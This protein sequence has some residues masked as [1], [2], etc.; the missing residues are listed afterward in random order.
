MYQLR[1]FFRKFIVCPEAWDRALCRWNMFRTSSAAACI[2]LHQGDHESAF[3]SQSKPSPVLVRL[4]SSNFANPLNTCYY[5]SYF[6][7]ALQIGVEVTTAVQQSNIQSVVALGCFK[8]IAS[9]ASAT[10]TEG[11]LAHHPRI[12]CRL[13]PHGLPC[14]PAI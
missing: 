11:C 4:R 8:S 14:L 12:L 7:R 5:L 1:L 10:V 3:P 13:P 9:L 2:L 6:S